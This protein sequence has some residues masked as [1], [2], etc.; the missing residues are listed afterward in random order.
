M[1][2]G[3]SVVRAA[4][5]PDFHRRS[6]ISTWSTG[7]WLR[8]G[9]GLSPPA[10]SFTD[11]GARAQQYAAPRGRSFPA[12]SCAIPH[13]SW[14]RDRACRRAE[15]PWTRAEPRCCTVRVRHPTPEMFRGLARSSPWRWRALTFDLHRRPLHGPEHT[16]HARL[17][18]GV[19]LEVRLADDE[20]HRDPAVRNIAGLV[21]LGGGRAA[22]PPWS[23]PTRGSCRWRSTVTVSSCVDPASRCRTTR[24][25]R[26]TSSWRC[27]TRSSSPTGCRATPAPAGTR[28]PCARP[29]STCTASTP[30][31][32]T[33]GRPGGRR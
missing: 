9:R 17:E 7:R 18:R 12:S 33:D 22:R 16:V 3:T 28:M 4:Y 26:T 21:H 29:R 2:T 32:A 11:P 10:R 23:S 19:A 13:A 30:R 20:P 27:S 14:P 1:T 6:R 5:H 15:T 25:G 24:C 31:C 8:S